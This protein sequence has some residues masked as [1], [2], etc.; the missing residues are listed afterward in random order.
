M[1]GGIKITLFTSHEHTDWP[2]NLARGA[3]STAEPGGPLGA[4]QL[5]ICP[6][7]LSP[8]TNHRPEQERMIKSISSVTTAGEV[9]SPLK[10]PAHMT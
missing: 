3:A 10:S 9:C 8:K 1:E 4:H 6:S 2:R 5:M 7:T